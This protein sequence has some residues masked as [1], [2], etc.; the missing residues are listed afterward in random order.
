[1]KQLLK[2]L[3]LLMS[4]LF[5][6]C[7][8]QEVFITVEFPE[9]PNVNTLIYSVPIAGKIYLGFVDT[10]KRNETGKFEIQMKISQPSFVT[11]WDQEYSNYV[12]LLIEQGNNYHVSMGAKKNVQITGMNEKGQMLYTTLPDPSYIEMQLS[13]FLRDTSMTLTSVQHQISEL[14]QADLL[15]F[16][17][18]LDNKEITKSYFNLVQKDR[19][20]YY[21]SLEARFSIIKTYRT[22]TIGDSLLV[23][24]KRIYD[25][26]PPD[27]ESLQFSSFWP[28]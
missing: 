6:C 14:K 5:T 24:L 22:K 7:N 15:K 2:A 27:D 4:L 10:L 3:T 21:A 9:Q 26:Y 8:K 11:I 18:L 13:S 28:E 19:D 16:K 25:Q 23:N 20:C 12:K 1:M 17:E